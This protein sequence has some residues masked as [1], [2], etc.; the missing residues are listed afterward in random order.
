MINIE[1]YKLVGSVL[2]EIVSIRD[3][4]NG[5]RMIYLTTQRSNLD[6]EMY[7]PTRGVSG[8]LSH[9]EEERCRESK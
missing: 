9:Q 4:G 1:D 8:G 7:Y 3:D 6:F 2:E 5:V